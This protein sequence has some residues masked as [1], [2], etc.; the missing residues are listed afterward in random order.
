MRAA[1]ARAFAAGWTEESL[2]DLAGKRLG[3][4]IGRQFPRAGTAV[5]YLGKGHNAADTL[6][7]LRVLRERFG[8]KVAVRAAFEAGQCAPLVA[9]KWQELGASG[10]R[11][12]EDFGWWEADQPLLLLDGLLGIGGKGGLRGELAILADEMRGLR[13]QAGARVAAVDLPSGVDGDSGEPTR[14]CVTADVTFTIG[15]AKR[16]L[17]FGHA[18]NHV[19]AL[20]LVPVE[21]LTFPVGGD[22]ELIAPQSLDGGKGPRPFDFH[23]GLAGNVALIAGSDRYPG[24]G[25]LAAL[26]ALRGGAGLVTL[27][28]PRSAVPAIAVQCPPEV[29]VRGYDQP[30]ELLEISCD[31][32]VFGCGLGTPDPETERVLLR[33]LAESEVPTVIDADGLNLLARS[34]SIGELKAN[35]VLTPHPGEF[36]RLAPDLAGLPREQAATAFASR[37]PAVLLLKGGRTVVTQAKRPLWCNSTGSPGMATGGQGDLLA[38]VIG[39][40][41]ATSCATLDAAAIG[42]WLCGRAAEIALAGGIESEE[43]LTA[44]DVARHLGRAFLDWKSGQ[45]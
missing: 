28:A 36:A 38:G 31:A 13:D 17:L 15:A 35:H 41:L 14:A 10:P 45:R 3:I 27:H 16:G 1:E 39:A 29:I 40:R 30:S 4:A 11:A 43:S 37:T 33:L 25:A 20:A 19:G 12:W 22:L 24:A 18:A 7:A 21:P 9:K 34:G 32:F 6:V 2:L 26:G 8:W 5:A 42:A 23:K 44:S